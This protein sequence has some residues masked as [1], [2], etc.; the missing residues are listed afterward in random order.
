MFQILTLYTI[1]ILELYTQQY[2]L[3]LLTVCS[4]AVSKTV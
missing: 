4:Q 2:I 1:R 3:V